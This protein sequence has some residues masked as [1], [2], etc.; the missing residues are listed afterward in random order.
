MLLY[1]LKLCGKFGIV[2]KLPCHKVSF[3]LIPLTISYIVGYE[4]YV[5][6]DA[7][8]PVA[9]STAQLALSDMEN[10]GT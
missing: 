9:E 5:V 6:E 2:K 1:F 4:T 3:V 8:R 7:S 10:R